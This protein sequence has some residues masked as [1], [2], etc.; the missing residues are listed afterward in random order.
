MWGCSL[1]A[2]MLFISNSPSCGFLNVLFESILTYPNKCIISVLFL[3]MAALWR[4][5]TRSINTCGLWGQWGVSLSSG[6][7][8]PDSKS[9]SMFDRSGLFVTQGLVTESSDFDPPAVFVWLCV[10][11]RLLC[12]SRH[13]LT[14]QSTLKTLTNAAVRK[15]L[16]RQYFRRAGVCTEHIMDIQ[17]HL[18]T[19]LNEAFHW[20][21]IFFIDF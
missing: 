14:L 13:R 16:I 18:Y 20:S 19:I 6:Q 7:V 10:L 15:V 17:W 1:L 9:E 4:D 12:N 8:S 5:R 11:K 21:I 2:G 3:Y